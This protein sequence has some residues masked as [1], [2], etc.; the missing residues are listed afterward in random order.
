MLRYNES[1]SPVKSIPG[2]VSATAEGIMVHPQEIKWFDK[3][4]SIDTPDG[5]P[6]RGN[7]GVLVPIVFNG[8]PTR[9]R[10]VLTGNGIVL[11]ETPV[12]EMPTPVPDE[13]CYLAA[14]TLSAE[15]DTPETVDVEV[16]RRTMSADPA[17]ARDLTMHKVPAS[18]VERAQDPA[19]AAR[20]AAKVRN[21][22]ALER[23]R[24]RAPSTWSEGD[25]R[26]LLAAWA[27]SQG[28]DIPDDTETSE[29]KRGG[30]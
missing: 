21:K 8:E 7:N 6:F 14:L 1:S 13:I 16:P 27:R 29:P 17:H 28:V 4:Y 10:V 20:R 25:V 11:D 2:L 5:G 22:A 15:G 3:V 23:V 9:Y 19:R 26:G 18:L 12:T 24:G 30:R